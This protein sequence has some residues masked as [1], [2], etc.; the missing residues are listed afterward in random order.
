MP[1]NDRDSV[2]H[3]EAARILGTS[4][5]AALRRGYLTDAEER[6]IDRTIERAEIR[7]AEKRDIRQAAAE[8]RDRARF[9]AKKQKAIDRATK[10]S[11]F[12]WL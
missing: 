3:R 7:E 11:G 9:E 2:N 1:I 10:R 5:L 6:R 12:S 8:A 4:L